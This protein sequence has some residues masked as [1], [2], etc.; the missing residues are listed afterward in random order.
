MKS[1]DRQAAHA[2]IV[3]Y[4]KKLD[5]LYPRGIQKLYEYS[6]GFPGGGSNGGGKGGHSDRTQMLAM[7]PDPFRHA[8]EQYDHLIGI[9]RDSLYAA[10]QI[11]LIAT[12]TELQDEALP[13]CRSCVRVKNHKGEPT[14]SPVARGHLCRWCDDF[15]RQYHEVPDVRILEY[16]AR[17]GKVTEQIVARYM[18]KA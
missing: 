8:L 11:M 10:Y 6:A 2:D 3:D 17:Y 18:V 16:R 7:K 9:A 5:P 12:N 15:K 13:A 4:A 14:Y 1:S